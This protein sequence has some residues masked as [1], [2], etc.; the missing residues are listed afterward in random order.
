MNARTTFD[1]D[2]II[3]TGGAGGLGHSQCLELGRR[4]A[5]VV[6]NDLGGS[7]LGGG[8][9][10]SLAQAVVDEITA[11]GGEAVAST[12]SVADEDGPEQL[13][14]TALDAFGRVDGMMSNAAIVRNT[15]FENMTDEDWDLT[16]SVDFRAVAR[17]FQAAY[18]V[19][20]ENGGGRL[21][22]MTSTSGLAGAYGQPN[23]AAAKTGLIGLMKTIAWEGNQYG[24]RA[25]LV[26]PGATDT[27][28]TAA[29]MG[30]AGNPAYTNRPPELAFDMTTGFPPGFI[31]ADK[32]TAMVL[33]LLHR[34][35]P[36]SGQ[37]F[38]ASAGIFHRFAIAST[39]PVAIPGIPTMED[40]ADHWAEIVGPRLPREVDKEAL[41]WGG[42]NYA[43]AFAEL[44]GGD[45]KA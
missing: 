34:S 23:Y 9:D 26:A 2:V 27:R 8:A 1:G 10:A 7:P 11:A 3:V 42:S 19:M 6:V 37:I 5:R 38:S 30:A 14:Q 22:V 4:G 17:G 29:T 16:M 28:A 36:V 25:N 32:V 40:I 41:V 15:L 13:V 35:V 20:K 45:E 21:V 24:I 33:T 39:D 43:D 44:P 12:V 31:V 18:R